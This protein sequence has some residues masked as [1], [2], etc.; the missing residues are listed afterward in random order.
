MDVGKAI[1]ICHHFP[2]NTKYAFVWKEVEVPMYGFS[3]CFS[4]RI[5]L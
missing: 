3:L 5:S 2:F 1:L 4:I